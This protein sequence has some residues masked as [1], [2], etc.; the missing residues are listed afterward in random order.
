MAVA[1]LATRLS[2]RTASAVRNLLCL[3]ENPHRSFLLSFRRVF[4]PEESAF[5]LR[6]AAP[7]FLVNTPRL[8]LSPQTIQSIRLRDARALA[9]L[10]FQICH[11]ELKWQ[12]GSLAMES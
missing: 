4:N 12:I 10:T 8:S 3:R 7:I 5:F 6:N 9:G 1:L 2:F 11:T